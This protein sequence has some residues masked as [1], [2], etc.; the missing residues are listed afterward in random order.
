MQ[1]ES[2]LKVGIAVKDI[3]RA[4][5]CYSD[6]LG[7]TP[8]EIV[9]YEP[10][11]M[12]YC[13]LQVGQLSFLELMEPTSPGSPIGRFIESRGEG[14]QHL[15]LKVADIDA[16]VAELKQKGFRFVQDSPIREHVGFGSAK[17]IFIQPQSTGGVLVQLVELVEPE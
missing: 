8:S 12:R 3:D 1:I 9:A 17:F 4:I 14:L 10:F 7:L 11:G 6:T 15:S 13:M 2:V 5:G 16:A